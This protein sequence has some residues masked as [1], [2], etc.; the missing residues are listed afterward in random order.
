MAE[1]GDFMEIRRRL[2]VEDLLNRGIEAA[3]A[4]NSRHRPTA[5]LKQLST[6]SASYRAV[7]G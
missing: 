6:G 5:W 2:Q 4:A 7:D 3:M 1:L